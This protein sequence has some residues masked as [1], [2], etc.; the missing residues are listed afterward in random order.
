VKDKQCTPLGPVIRTEYTTSQAVK[1]EPVGLP[2][3]I[4]EEVPG[5]AS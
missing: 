3:E 5:I 4:K 2:P 1:E